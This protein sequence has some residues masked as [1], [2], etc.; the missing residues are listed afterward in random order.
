ML[1]KNCGRMKDF[2]SIDKL[3]KENRALLEKFGYNI[4]YIGDKKKKPSK[5]ESYKDTNS[6][7]RNELNKIKNQLHDS[8]DAT[9]QSMSM[10]MTADAR[11]RGSVAGV[12]KPLENIS[13]KIL[14]QSKVEGASE[15]VADDKEL[16]ANRTTIDAI[17]QD[18][19][20]GFNTDTKADMLISRQEKGNK[21]IGTDVI[22]AID[23]VTNM[24]NT[25]FSSMIDILDEMSN[26]LQ[27]LGDVAFKRR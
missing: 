18:A 26:N 3:F 2:K 23:R 17:R 12:T 6:Y 16:K 21:I 11:M 4:G 8:L 10:N 22:Q 7:I 9:K 1:Q 20:T 15:R 13:E 25:T 5:Q 24:M 14:T 27:I 19:S